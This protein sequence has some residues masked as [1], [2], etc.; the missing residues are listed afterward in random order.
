MIELNKKISQFTFHNSK[1][2]WKGVP[3]IY[4]KYRI[5]SH[6]Y[7]KVKSDNIL[8]LCKKSQNFDDKSVIFNTTP[9]LKNMDSFVQLWNP[10]FIY[11]GDRYSNRLLLSID[12]FMSKYQHHKITLCVGTITKPEHVEILINEFGV[13]IVDISDSLFSE[14]CIHSSLIS[15]GFTMSN[16][17]I[18]SD[19]TIID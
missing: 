1:N 13:D 3:L 18:N 2:V 14:E 6:E 15:G 11:I 12:K 16:D 8:G 17:N 7:K 4:K 9:E 5:E 10:D 19:F